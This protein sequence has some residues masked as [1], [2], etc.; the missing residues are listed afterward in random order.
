MEK[1]QLERQK[2]PKQKRERGENF[3][4]VAHSATRQETWE[5]GANTEDAEKPLTPVN[6]NVSRIHL[7]GASRVLS[8]VF[9]LFSV[10][11]VDLILKQSAPTL[12]YLGRTA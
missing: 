9:C 2:G 5:M 6:F 1:D 10:F 4:I 7:R 11:F 3:K 8:S 12:W